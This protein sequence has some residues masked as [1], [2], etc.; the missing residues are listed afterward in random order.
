ML[1][2]IFLASPRLG[3]LIQHFSKSPMKRT[4]HY[5][6]KRRPLAPSRILILLLS[7]VALAAIATAA[8]EEAEVDFSILEEK[9]ALNAYMVPQQQLELLKLESLLEAAEDDRRSGQFLAATKPSNLNPNQDVKGAID[10]G[11][12]M[13]ADSETR[14]HSIRVRMVRLLESVSIAREKKEAVDLTKYNFDTE[15][16]QL[17]DIFPTS[18]QKLLQDCW[19]QNYDTIFFHDVFKRSSAG[20]ES[21][22]PE[23][24]N[25]I[26]DWL[27]AIDGNKFSI[28][29]PSEFK[30]ESNSDHKTPRF[31][32]ENAQFFERDR[33]AL[34]IS[35]FIRPNQSK[36]GF[37]SLRAIDLESMVIVSAEII[38]ISNLAEHLGDEAADLEDQTPQ[39]VELKDS[40]GVI[41]LL[42]GLK[43]PYKFRIQTGS[44]TT[45][46]S[47]SAAFITTIRKNT[48]LQLLDYGFIMD[49]Y[50]SPL[51]D[52]DRIN[53]PGNAE[54]QIEAQDEEGLWLI[55][56]VADG[57]DRNLELGKLTLK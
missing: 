7:A 4:P 16:A 32:Y 47:A 31:S 22:Q 46:H 42:A 34:L 54:I 37:L 27:V 5:L 39:R 36:T 1:E 19:A 2:E 52:A 43:T 12:K 28:R 15:S 53:H 30:L 26:Y 21:V 29:V 38:K 9:Q 50:G 10:R 35:E 56:A 8:P 45:D 49:A 23:L 48:N 25:Q 3:S 40:E 51:E 17:E 6:G 11:K 33:K 57:S 18:A 55:Q 41:D 24:R 13:I 20:L 14:I 44:E